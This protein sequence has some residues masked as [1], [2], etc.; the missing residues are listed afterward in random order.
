LR[1]EYVFG[2]DG[3]PVFWGPAM[4]P[5]DPAR[6]AQLRC[7]THISG[8]KNPGYPRELLRHEVQGRVL[9]KLRF[10]NDDQAP[11]AEVLTPYR[12]RALGALIEEWVRGFRLPCYAGTPINTNV[13]FIFKFEGEDYGFKPMTLL[14][15][16]ARAKNLKTEGL[17]MDTR[18]MGCPFD[19]R[20]NYRQPMLP[21]SVGVK[22]AADVHRQPLVDWL[23]RAELDLPKHLSDAIFADTAD[24][25]VPCAH[26][27]ITP[28]AAP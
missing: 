14:Q 23:A 8:E 3:R 27:G 4:D 21:N 10:F 2:A 17:Q 7:L 11:Q 6:E 22:G 1:Q 28:T 12:S 16:V 26:F 13:V 25:H 5:E 19:V 24:I 20:L 18:T 15:F 9:A